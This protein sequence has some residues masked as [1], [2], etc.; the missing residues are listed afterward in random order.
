MTNSSPPEQ[1]PPRRREDEVIAVVVTFLAFAAIFG[2]GV[3]QGQAWDPSRFVSGIFT[4]PSP[5]PT[6]EPPAPNPQASISPTPSPI[7]EGGP[8]L[9]TTQ[10][11]VPISPL[12]PGSEQA[13]LGP[14][15]SRVPRPEQSPVPQETDPSATVIPVVPVPSDR[16]SPTPEASKPSPSPTPTTPGTPIAFA[17]VSKDFWAYPFITALSARGIIGGFPDGSF[18]PNQPVTRGQFAVQLQKAFTK[19]DQSPPKN[20]TD[21]PAN[22]LWFEAVD[23]AVKANF[24]SGY[25]DGTFQTEQQVSR[26]EAVASIARGLGLPEPT[27]P[28]AVLQGYVDRNQVPD[29]ARGKVAAA[30]QAG[31]FS[32]DPDTRELKPTQAATRAD[33]AALVYQAL[34]RSM[35]NGDRVSSRLSVNNSR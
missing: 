19:P 26:V 6:D 1:R 33:I 15:D 32:G 28:G 34:E 5:A 24:M 20:F 12:Q 13:T 14:Y 18:R 9:D 23:R 31:L 25:P 2:W 22:N 30:I 17:D 11:D 27:D 10:P 29:W 21:V 8:S 3:S 4:T 7:P 16:F 35:P